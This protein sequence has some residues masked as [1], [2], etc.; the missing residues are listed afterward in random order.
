VHNNPVALVTG[1]NTGIG[2]QVAK[3]LAGHGF[4]VVVGSRALD[5][6]LTAAAEIQGE[7]TAVQLDVTDA[8]SIAAAA[9]RVRSEF[10]RLDVLI[11]N[12]GVSF[13]GD[14]ST[15]LEDRAK[16]GLLTEVSID[17]VRRIFETNVIGL[18][19]LTQ[20][21]LPLLLKAPAA[22][23]VNVGSSGS[24]LT[25]TADPSNPH[26]SMFGIYPTTKSALHAAT[27]GFAT[28]LE[29]TGI[30]VN[31][32]DPGFTATALNNF[33]GAKTVE[34]GSPAHRRDGSHRL[35]RPHRNLLRRRRPIA[36]VRPQHKI[37]ARR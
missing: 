29:P 16:S 32:A 12:A 36:L 24:S 30:K 26:R 18:I 19:A 2:F 11:N 22:R 1:A 25:L 14:P 3:D 17:V 31:I 4:T 5:R 8:D 7:A 15:P 13:L 33:Q 27:L 20:A 35:G 37:T 28:A 6:G 23:I 21:L 9:D 10:G 34:R